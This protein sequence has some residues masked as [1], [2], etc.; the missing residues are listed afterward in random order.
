[1]SRWSTR[2]Q[3]TC[4]RRTL[5]RLKSDIWEGADGEQQMFQTNSR[6]VEVGGE[7]TSR[8]NPGGFRRTL[9]RLKSPADSPHDGGHASFRRTLVRLK[10]PL[11]FSAGLGWVSFQTN[12]R[13][14]EVSLSKPL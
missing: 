14:V 2:T 13:E 4:F 5:V 1:M 11:E 6:E 12:S 7:V 8:Q 9:V 10:Y 3:A